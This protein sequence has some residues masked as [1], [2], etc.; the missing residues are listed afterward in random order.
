[1]I[2][3]TAINLH[4]F[5]NLLMIFHIGIDPAAHRISF[6][7][8]ELWLINTARADRQSRICDCLWPK[9]YFKRNC[10][11][12]LICELVNLRDD[13]FMICIKGAGK[14]TVPLV[15][16]LV[17]KAL[18]PNSARVLTP[19]LVLSRNFPFSFSYF[20]LRSNRSIIPIVTSLALI[21]KCKSRG[22]RLA[23]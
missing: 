21:K 12:E 18:R 8:C 1:M 9:Q 16:N 19:S 11:V 14:A 2:F 20:K 23:A 15:K 22:N 17:E 6:V 4:L 10:W 13:L 3:V 5:K 7:P